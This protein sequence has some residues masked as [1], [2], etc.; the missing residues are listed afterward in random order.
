M[1]QGG[2]VWL[3]LKNG[4]SPTERGGGSELPVPA[5]VQISLGRNGLRTGQQAPS[6]LTRT[7]VRPHPGGLDTLDRVELTLPFP[8]SCLSRPSR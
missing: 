6:H 4:V 1:R 5:S 2:R 8:C 3:D 7:P